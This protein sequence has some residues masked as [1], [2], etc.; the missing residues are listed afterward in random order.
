MAVV[1]PFSR[2]P[3]KGAETLVWLVDSEEAGSENGGY[4]VDCKR[5]QP[6]PPARDMDS[7]RRLWDLT[8]QQVSAQA[9]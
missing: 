9:R 7:A 4:F 3:E 2:S 6:E 1:K 5:A 8:E